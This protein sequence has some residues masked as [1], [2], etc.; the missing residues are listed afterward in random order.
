MIVLNYRDSVWTIWII[1]QL[2]PSAQ[3]TNY[4]MCTH[5]EMYALNATNSISKSLLHQINV[6]ETNYTHAYCG[7]KPN[8]KLNRQEA[9]ERYVFARQEKNHGKY[10]VFFF[11]SKQLPFNYNPWCDFY[12]YNLNQTIYQGQDHIM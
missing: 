9:F 11:F 3:L 10:S 5:H 2:F 7:I 12:I 1:Q 4:I 6:I 8:T